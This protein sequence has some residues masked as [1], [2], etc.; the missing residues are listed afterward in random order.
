VVLPPLFD[1]TPL[2]RLGE[3]VIFDRG[4][5]RMFRNGRRLARLR[6]IRAVQVV[7]TGYRNPKT[8]VM[9]LLKDSPPLTLSTDYATLVWFGDGRALACAVA[10]FVG[11]PLVD[12]GQ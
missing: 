8:C 1:L 3:H 7:R 9:L 5:G 6:D 10:K 2:G 12:N 4:C 11:V